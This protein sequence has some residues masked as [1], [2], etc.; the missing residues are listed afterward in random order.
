MSGLMI[1]K[2]NKFWDMMPYGAICSEQILLLEATAI[3]MPYHRA[4]QYL[5][6]NTDFT[7]KTCQ[8]WAEW[9]K[10]RCPDF[11]IAW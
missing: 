2:T 11:P 3:Y 10:V 1:T 8:V 9:L 4:V 6:S 5:W 7:M